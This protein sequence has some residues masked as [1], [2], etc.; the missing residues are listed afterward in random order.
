[1]FFH[2]EGLVRLLNFNNHAKVGT[3]IMLKISVEV[4]PMTRV[5]PT[6][7]IGDTVTIIGAMSTENPITVVMAERNTATPVERV[8]SRTQSR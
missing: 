7:R 8:I 5:I 3:K 6:E 2:I 4:M 1:M